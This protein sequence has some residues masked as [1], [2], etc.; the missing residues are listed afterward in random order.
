M[1]K[2]Q[3]KSTASYL[4][5]ISKGIAIVAIVGNI[6]QGK[7]DVTSIVFGIAGV[8]IFFIIAYIIEGGIKNE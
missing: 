1:N 8:I 4:Y 5:D 3:R 2:K 6:V 7:T